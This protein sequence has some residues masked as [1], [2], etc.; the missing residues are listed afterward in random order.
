MKRYRILYIYNI[1]LYNKT[2]TSDIKIHICIQNFKRNSLSKIISKWRQLNYWAIEI[3]SWMIRRFKIQKLCKLLCYTNREWIGSLLKSMYVQNMTKRSTP[4][5]IGFMKRLMHHFNRLWWWMSVTLMKSIHD[6][7][8]S[9][10]TIDRRSNFFLL[11]NLDY[12]FVISTHIQMNHSSNF[13][14]CRFQPA[15]TFT[16]L[17]LYWIN[18]ITIVVKLIII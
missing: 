9:S 6:N 15:F 13:Q 7:Q 3:I 18:T 16:A 8:L 11:N 10:R 17:K 14:R 12:I 5:Q 1:L 2:F 4:W